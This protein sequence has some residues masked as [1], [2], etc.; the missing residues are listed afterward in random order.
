MSEQTAD[1]DRGPAAGAASGA[2][3]MPDAGTPAAGA[4]IPGLPADPAAEDVLADSDAPDARTNPDI[5]EVRGADDATG[6]EGHEEYG[7]RSGADVQPATN[8]DP[9]SFLDS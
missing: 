6:T 2:H 7:L 9:A 8:D 5:D 3:E 1:P 4:A